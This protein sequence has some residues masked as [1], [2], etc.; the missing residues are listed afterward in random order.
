MTELGLFVYMPFIIIQESIQRVENDI[1]GLQY[2]GPILCT[3]SGVVR[4][5]ALS[6]SLYHLGGGFPTFPQQSIIDHE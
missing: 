5:E 2:W 1:S 6:S 3:S 4:D